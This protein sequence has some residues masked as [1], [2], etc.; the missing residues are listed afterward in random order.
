MAQLALN[1]LDTT[2][3][4][5]GR[6]VYTSIA[7]LGDSGAVT[8]YTDSFNC[9]IP[10]TTTVTAT[11]GNLTVSCDDEHYH[12]PTGTS[13]L[14]SMSDGAGATYQQITMGSG[15]IKTGDAARTNLTFSY[16]RDYNSSDSMYDT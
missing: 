7:Y 12:P 9:T 10:I 14:L 6:T 16:S 4:T 5:A 11:S 1:N 8:N 15:A 2:L 3:L 13:P